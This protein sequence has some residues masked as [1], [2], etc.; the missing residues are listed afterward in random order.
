MDSRYAPWLGRQERFRKDDPLLQYLNQARDA[1]HHGLD[2]ILKRTPRKAVPGFRS[3]RDD[4]EVKDLVTERRKVALEV[5]DA[6]E[7]FF[8][9]NGIELLPVSNR[10][11]TYP[12]PG[13][14]HGR[15]I[16][17]LTPIEFAVLGIRFHDELLRQA[18]ENFSR[19]S[20]GRGGESA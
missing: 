18:R 8:R 6:I 16:A 12:I 5:H 4:V 19:Q 14:H 7:G 2:A 3:V 15:A 20:P 10:G 11:R 9:P 13:Q 17:R 1:D